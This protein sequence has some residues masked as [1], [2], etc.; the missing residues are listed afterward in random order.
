MYCTETD[1][2][3]SSMII[4]TPRYLPYSC[5]YRDSALSMMSIPLGS[6]TTSRNRVSEAPTQ[7]RKTAKKRKNDRGIDMGGERE[8]RW[9]GA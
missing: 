6:A 5:E 2:S 1:G 4:H 8:I 7:K 3:K 9:Y